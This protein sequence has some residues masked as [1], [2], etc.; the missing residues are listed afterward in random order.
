MFTVKI[1]QQ[2]IVKPFVENPIADA[3]H[4]NPRPDLIIDLR[5]VFGDRRCR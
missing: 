1:T 5:D 4:T 2:E 3:S